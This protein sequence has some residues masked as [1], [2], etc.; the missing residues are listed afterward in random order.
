M[1][2][3]FQYCMSKPPNKHNNQQC[4]IKAISNLEK[5]KKRFQS[6]LNLE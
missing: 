6:M 4:N 5:K 1:L 3:H 2:L